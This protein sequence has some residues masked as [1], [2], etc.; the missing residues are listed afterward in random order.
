MHRPPTDG[1]GRLMW[2]CRRLD[3]TLCRGSP[4][5][6]ITGV[7]VGVVIREQIASTMMEIRAA[8]PRHVAAG[9]RVARTGPRRRGGAWIHIPR[10]R[11]GAVGAI[12]AS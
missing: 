8:Q 3:R 9:G 2:S 10:A 7:T 4:A 6:Q 11:G 5:L 12:A 1:R